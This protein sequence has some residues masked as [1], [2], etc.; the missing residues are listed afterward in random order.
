[1]PHHR[2]P[3]CYVLY[4]KAV[5][6][7]KKNETLQRS[8]MAKADANHFTVHSIHHQLDFGIIFFFH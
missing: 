5:T 3:E 2:S 1:M 7:L 4:D 8:M 6:V